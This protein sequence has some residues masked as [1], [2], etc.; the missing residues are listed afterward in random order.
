MIPKNLFPKADK[1]AFVIML[2]QLLSF[3][4]LSVVFLIIVLPIGVI[5]VIE[6]V[7]AAVFLFVLVFGAKRF[8]GRD[9]LAVAVFFVYL[10]AILLASF[11]AQLLP[12]DAINLR[13]QV[14]AAIAVITIIFFVLFRIFLSRDFSHGTVIS[15]EKDSAVVQAEFDF[16]AGIN[17]GTYVVRSH[18]HFPKGEKVKLKIEQ[19]FFGRKPKEITE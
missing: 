4:M 3:A 12:L 1:K 19:G 15:S 17:G 8:F 13:F 2:L 7:L 16:L 5:A 10:L 18:K 14:L 11:G 9:F 6:L